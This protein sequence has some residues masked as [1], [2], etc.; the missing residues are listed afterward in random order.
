MKK[1]F[2]I[3]IISA[4]A[5]A[6]HAQSNVLPAPPQKGDMFIK[7]ATIHVG[8]G[9]VIE[10][11]IIQIRDGKIEKVGKDIVIPAGAQV[12][13]AGGKQVYPG[14][15]L[16]VSSLGLI[17]TGSIRASNDVREIGD[18]NPNVHSI[19]AYN[20]DSK[21]INTLRSNGILVANIVPQGSFLAGSSTV[22]QLD[23]WNWQDA[24]Y[25]TDGGMHLYMPSLL[26]RMGFGRGGGGGGRPGGPN[27]GTESDPVKEGLDQIEKLKAFF[28]EAKAYNAMTSHE[29]TNLKYDAVKNLFNKTQKFYVHGNTVKQ[30]LVAIDFVKEFGFDVVIVGGSESWQIPDL[31]KQHNISIVLQQ[32]HSLPTTPD[33][34]VDQPYKTAAILQKA[35]VLFA[36]S[37]DDGQTRGRNIAFNAGTAATYG[38]TKEEALAAITLNAAKIMGVADK[39]GSIEAGKDA[40]IIISSGDILDMSTSNVTDAFVQG[41][42]INLDDKQKQLNERYLQKYELKP[43]KAF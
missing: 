34:D 29:E 43:K 37:D 12:T 19:V 7:N 15:I 30:M 40:N 13:D 42:K 23:A 36:I 8:N 22:V 9:T 33:D 21:V 14:L 6:V 24:S 4:I 16:P 26:P 3:A 41:R 1:I 31:L 32:M 35:G 10:N 17:E 39:T 5:V 2:F 11:G 25:K 38:L 18:M 27:A 28:R 20:T